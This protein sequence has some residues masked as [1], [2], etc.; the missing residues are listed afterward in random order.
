ML[1]D[2]KEIFLHC[3]TCKKSTKRIN[4]TKSIILCKDSKPFEQWAINVIGLMP[5]NLYDK[6]FIITAIDYCTNWLVAYAT[7]MHDG[8]TIRIFFGTKIILKFGTLKC[9]IIDCGR[10]FISYDTQVYLQDKEIEHYT[11]TSYH[12]QE[13][14]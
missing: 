13:N 1:P 10:E 3:E 2:I 6:C 4:N 7:K 14:S 8:K 11:T 5:H 9:L 12:L